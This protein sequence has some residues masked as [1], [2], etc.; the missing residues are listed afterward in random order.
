MKC[1]DEILQHYF[2]C[3]NVFDE[4]GDLTDEGHEAYFKLTSLIEDVC[5]LTEEDVSIE[6]IETLDEIV[7]EKY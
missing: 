6:M 5:A 4:Q 1:L 2:G 7:N 3:K